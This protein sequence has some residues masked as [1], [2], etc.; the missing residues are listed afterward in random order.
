MTSLSKNYRARDEASPYGSFPDMINQ[1]Y[2]NT[3]GYD[4]T[5]NHDIQEVCTNLLLE[6]GLTQNELNTLTSI[7]L[8]Q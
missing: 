6:A 8:E 5:G 2:D 7:M 1:L 3:A 4:H